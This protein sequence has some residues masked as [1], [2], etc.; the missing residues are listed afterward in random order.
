MSWDTD[1]DRLEQSSCA[2]GNG[3]VVR[4]EYSESDDWN[5]SRGGYYGQKIQC[6]D[7]EKKYKIEGVTKYYNAPPWK[8]DGIIYTEYLVPL[9]MTLNLDIKEE[10]LYLNLDERIVSSFE[11]EQLNEI[12]DDMIANKYS[13]RLKL[14][15][16]RYVVGMYEST[17]K[18]R[19][20]PKIIELL[21]GCVSRYESYQWNPLRMK[22]RNEEERLRIEANARI[23][24][25]VI[26]KSYKL[27]FKQVKE[28]DDI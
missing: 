24:E 26:S 11:K 18:K 19:G 7:C 15:D 17:H 5:R 12:V 2:C 27:N 9:N 14:S 21:Q 1:W 13:T 28:V 4:R 20:L 10:R 3:S 8:S 23:I 6:D 16:S 25:D 22:E